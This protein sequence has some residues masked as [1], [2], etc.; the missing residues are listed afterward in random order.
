M[1]HVTVEQR[2][3][4]EQT[5][6]W[7]IAWRGDAACE[8]AYQAALRAGND[9]QAVGRAWRRMAGARR[10][11]ALGDRKASAVHMRAD[12]AGIDTL[13]VIALAVDKLPWA[14]ART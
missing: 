1:K 3:A 14:D 11:V 13:A 5:A 7:G 10:T 8:A 2:L 12:A 9:Q 6:A 4:H